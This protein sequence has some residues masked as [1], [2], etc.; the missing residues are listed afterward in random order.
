MMF[1]APPV[2]IAPFEP[3]HGPEILALAGRCLGEGYLEDL[4][5]VLARPGLV[6]GVAMAPTG[7]AGFVFG[8]RLAPGDLDDLYADLS[9]R[10]RPPAVS[11]A[12]SAG[13]L[14]ILKTIAIDPAWQ[15]RGLGAELFRGCVERLRLDGADA[16]VVPAWTIS[17]RPNLGP[18]LDRAGCEPFAEIPRPWSFECD[19]AVF[20]CPHRAEGAGCVCGLRIYGM[21]L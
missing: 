16:L 18:V 6:F 15:G 8:W 9:G 7:L 12:E 20:T 21:A 19:H 2:Q 5:P 17:G 4:N 3:S 11:A 1:D 10:P 13:R 14:A